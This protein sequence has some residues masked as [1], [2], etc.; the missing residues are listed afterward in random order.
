MHFEKGC[1]TQS[2]FLYLLSAFSFYFFVNCVFHNE[3]KILQSLN[4]VKATLLKFKNGAHIFKLEHLNFF[5][6][7][8]LNLIEQLPLICIF[9][10]S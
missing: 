2:L 3:I 5:L 9:K 7:K 1:F 10:A 8:L 6:V 4:I